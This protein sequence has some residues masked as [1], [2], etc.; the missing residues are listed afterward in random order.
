MAYEAKPV[1]DQPFGFLMDSPA[2]PLI[3]E[4]RQRRAAQMAATERTPTFGELGDERRAVQA[5]EAEMQAEL[6]QAV[7]EQVTGEIKFLVD[8][9]NGEFEPILP[10]QG[11][12]QPG[13]TEILMTVN[14][15]DPSQP[16]ILATGKR[17]TSADIARLGNP[18]KQI[19][20]MLRQGF[21]LPP[22]LQGI[23]E[24]MGVSQAPPEETPA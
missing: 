18:E 10:G 17:V 3:N 7:G 20:P 6:P 8:T 13:P 19:K 23:A 14:Q 1:E 12:P 21:E 5:Q 4:V 22:E 24:Q 16:N 2:G 15:E 9:T 11:D